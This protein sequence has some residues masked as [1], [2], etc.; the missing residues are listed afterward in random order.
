MSSIPRTICSWC[1]SRWHCSFAALLLL[2]SSLSIR[3]NFCCSLITESCLACRTAN[4]SREERRRWKS[5]SVSSVDYL[6]SISV[7]CAPWTSMLRPVDHSS[8]TIVSRVSGSDV[9]IYESTRMQRWKS[10]VDTHREEKGE[11]KGQSLPRRIGDALDLSLTEQLEE[12]RCLAVVKCAERLGWELVMVTLPERER[13]RVRR[14]PWPYVQIY[15]RINSFAM[16]TIDR[17]EPV[18]SRSRRRSSSPSILVQ[19]ACVCHS[20]PVLSWTVLAIVLHS[21]QKDK[22]LSLRRP[23]KRVNELLL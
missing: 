10:D 18:V 4:S 1:F 13:E 23:T 2:S 11:W 14:A 12:V 7:L 22:Q 8:V 19:L 16:S 6:P 21:Y 15:N 5:H 17:N 20:L 3:I 9:R